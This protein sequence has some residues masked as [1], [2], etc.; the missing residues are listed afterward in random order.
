MNE[1]KA[2]AFIQR[3]LLVKSILLSLLVFGIVA[4]NPAVHLLQAS[5]HKICEIS[6]EHRSF[7]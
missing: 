1:A 6:G 3:S 7:G 4:A 2:L 5:A